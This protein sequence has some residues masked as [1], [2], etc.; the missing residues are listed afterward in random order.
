[1]TD[2][3]AQL[4]RLT[5]EQRALLQR[6]MAAKRPDAIP[7]R[8]GEGPAPLSFAQRRLWFMQQINPASTAYN[9][10]TVL[11]LTGALDTGAMTQAF[12]AL[13]DRHQ[14]LRTRYQTAAD[15]APQQVPDRAPGLTLID[16]SGQ[17]LDSAH[18][19]IAQITGQ[20]FDLT[21][22]PLRA[23]LLRLAPDDHVLAIGLHHIVADRWSLGI[24]V[25]DLAVL[26]DA[27]SR[28]QD[29]PLALVALHMPD[30]AL[31]QHAQAD[32]VER[33]QLDY[34]RQRLCDAP[35][36][37]LPRDFRPVPGTAMPGGFLP[38]DLPADLAGSA[39]DMAARRGVSLFTLMLTAF[40]ALL[41]RYCDTDD[42]VV[43][44]DVSNRDRPET[45]GM[46]G[47]LVNTLTLRSD[48]SGA[49]FADALTRME[50]VLR[51]AFAHQDVPLDQ[52]VE[53]LNPERRAG[54]AIPLFRAKFDLQ[55]AERLPDAVHGIRLQRFPYQEQTAK[56]EL[57]FNLED[58][59]DR[60][61]GRVEYRADLYRPDT[62]AAMSAHYQ[63][64]LALMLAQP[65]RPIADLP[66]L[67]DTERDDLL[68]LAQGPELP[69]HAATLHTAFQV[70]VNR[71][72]DAA[73]IWHDGQSVTYGELDAMAN[74]VAAALIQ[75]DMP[76][77]TR[78]G[79]CMG[80]TPA[81]IAAILGTLKAECA[82]VPL[83]P[84]YPPARIGFM[85]Q[86]SGAELVLTDG[87]VTF[88]AETLDVT[89]LPPAPRPD[90]PRGTPDGLAVIIYTSG[91]TGQPKG[92]ALE[93]RNILSR[94][95]WAG[96]TFGADDLAG[97]LFG[98]SVSFDLSLFEIFATLGNGGRIV[99]AQTLLDLP[100]LHDAGVTMLNTVPSL[101]RELVKNGDLPA[102]VR[103]VNLAGE[104][105]PPALL[106]RLRQFPQLRTIN[107]LYGPTEDA[108]YDAGNPVQDEPE[109]PM[110]IGRPFPGTRLH[111]LD[112]HGNLLPRGAAGEIC[113]AGA[114][115]ARGYL[116][117]PDLTAEKFIADPYAPGRMY[118]SGDRARWRAD[119]RIDI[120]GR[121]D[122]QVKL[123]GMRIETGEIE[124]TLEARPDVAEAIVLATG[125]PGDSDRQL[126]AHVAP[127]PGMIVTAEILRAHLAGLLPAHLVPQ[128]WNVMD[129]LPRMPNGKIDRRALAQI[130]VETAPA[131]PPA[132]DTEARII[133]IWCDMLDR[134]GIGATDDFF[135][136]GGHSLLAMRLLIRLKD[137]FAVDLPLG[138]LFQALTPR[139]QAALILSASTAAPQDQ[140]PTAG[141]SDA[142]VE[143]LL[144]QMT[145][146][147]AR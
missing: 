86:D 82:Y 99:L 107:N 47:P 110:P 96:Q 69:P 131:E 76:P 60:I 26:Y 104:F 74:A 28:G 146:E 111:I 122:G 56:Y 9:M 3:A 8:T 143:A 106:D 77:E 48:L 87:T 51:D 116:N 1:M 50:S 81:L 23:A 97:V 98:T 16:L 2:L 94:V 114:G 138:A 27:A 34:W 93:H 68:A 32:Q 10:M 125:E 90:H 61:A 29:S 140:D 21:Q 72:P 18:S 89:A 57:R 78:V 121:I 14:A 19:H 88:A 105:F 144:A 147:P 35:A 22:V 101:L 113:L 109:R 66:M 91:S 62:I 127:P 137:E 37:D 129:V 33:R 31:W 75:R 41:S 132:N 85:A 135:A 46:I 11:R 7:R 30:F 59:G 84:A 118:R 120:L 42:V 15:G 49:S 134:K 130:T 70:Q 55:Q 54:E 73:A 67:S 52:V 20:P 17:P 65:D 92:V 117:R 39:R 83:D 95:A 25:R 142:E 119:G 145:E 53:A 108:I 13:T 126:V 24:M 141:L 12:A 44:S 63:R 103:A 4:A 36:L 102:S 64:L 58:H 40:S 38:F 124:A 128:R 80:R 43:G 6:R 139:S 5:P 133:A 123:R 136:L 115:L 100:A 112:R 71:D 79:I 45:Q